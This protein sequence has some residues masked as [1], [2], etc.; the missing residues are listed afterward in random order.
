M[1]NDNRFNNK[2][3]EHLIEKLSLKK[4]SIPGLLGTLILFDGSLIHRG[5]PLKQNIRYVITNYYCPK[6]K[7]D[8]QINK[9]SPVIRSKDEVILN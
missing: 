9:I 1:S 5:S 7:V 2:E 4:I 3:I 8:E 6:L